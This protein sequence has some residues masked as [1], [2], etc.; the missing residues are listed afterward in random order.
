MNKIML[1]GLLA[2]LVLLLILPLITADPTFYAVA[3]F[4]L[5]YATAAIGWNIF[6]GYSGYVS[7]GYAAFMGIG[8]YTL[9]IIC[10]RLHL[11]GGYLVFLLVPVGGLVAAVLSIPIGWV[12]LRTRRVTF[13]VVTIAISF[14][15][16]SLALNL[17]SFTGG[18]SGILL[19]A[20][21]WSG[22]YY[23]MPY[24]YVAIVLV[25]IAFAVAWWIRNSKY[26]LGLLAIRDDEDRASGLGVKTWASKL[27]AYCISAF[28]GGMVGAVI[29][30]YNGTIFPVEAFD[31]TLNVSVALMS[32]LGGVGTLAGP[33]LG[34]FLLEPFQ[35]YL[36]IQYGSLSLNLVILGAILL[37]VILVLPEGILVTFPKL[38]RKRT[39]T[40][41]AP[42]AP[43]Q[44]GQKGAVL[45]EK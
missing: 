42:S 10:D 9:A 7:L 44:P 25:V 18:S 8:G 35:E 13:V 27:S 17:S 4:T 16:Q 19:P 32:F 38:W 15:L 23:N 5:L 21:E 6:S 40:L 26:G 34:A 29:A 31:S 2:L 36:T 1:G 12:A 24:Y 37:A 28:L 11:S 22:D 33:L 41:V 43:H 30:Y 3:I 14:I 20:S 45:V 39:A